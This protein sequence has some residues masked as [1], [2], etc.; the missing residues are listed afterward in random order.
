MGVWRIKNKE[1]RSKKNFRKAEKD[2]LKIGDTYY[3]NCPHR[4]ILCMC[5]VICAVNKLIVFEQ[6][7][8]QVNIIFINKI[9][10]TIYQNIY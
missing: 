9:H 6:G 7:K 10:Y 3:W 1:I 4:Q 5:H 8:C 2:E